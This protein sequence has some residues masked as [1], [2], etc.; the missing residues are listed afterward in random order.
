MSMKKILA[1]ALCLVLVAGLSIAGTVAYLTSVTDEVKNTFTVGDVEI[2]LTETTGTSYRI[3]PGVD[4]KKD[5]VVTFTEETDPCWLFVKVTA[6]NWPTKDVLGSN[7]ELITYSIA[8]GWQPLDGVAGVYY[9]ELTTKTAANTTY[10]VLAGD[11]A[12]ANGVIKVSDKLTKAQADKITVDPTLAFK[13]YAIQHDGF[14][15]AK[16]AWDEVSKAN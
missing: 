6:T 14:T 2:T 12:H 8:D 1:F 11:T 9:K 3:I 15:D 5:P 10:Y 4:L 13:A 7:E 16:A